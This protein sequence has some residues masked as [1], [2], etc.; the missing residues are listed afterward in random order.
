MNSV[1]DDVVFADEPSFGE[2]CHIKAFLS[3]FTNL[4]QQSKQHLAPNFL[5]WE[6][7]FYVFSLVK[8]KARNLKFVY[9]YSVQLNSW[10][11]KYVNKI[12]LK[13]EKRFFLPDDNPENIHMF[14]AGIQ[15]QISANIQRPDS[16]F[17]HKPGNR[18]G[19]H[20]GWRQGKSGRCHTDILNCILCK[21]HLCTSKWWSF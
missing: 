15:T 8:S 19:S 17:Q 16:K 9:K 18:I 1:L 20:P 2:S 14:S 7:W 3:V 11:E 4:E 5:N 13:F 12:D 6:N 10:V 21:D